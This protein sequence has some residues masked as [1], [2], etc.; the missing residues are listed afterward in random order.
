MLAVD[1]LSPVAN[2]PT[3][4]VVEAR[5]AL[6]HFVFAAVAEMIG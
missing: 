3:P 2:V 5:L 6:E 1:I 4:I